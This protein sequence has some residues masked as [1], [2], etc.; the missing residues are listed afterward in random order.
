MGERARRHVAGRYAGQVSPPEHRSDAQ[1]HRV[2]CRRRRL[3]LDRA[4]PAAQ[5]VR[6]VGHQRE[7]RVD[8][9]RVGGLPH[10]RPG[11]RILAGHEHRTRGDIQLGGPAL[12]FDDYPTMLRERDTDLVGLGH[13]DVVMRWQPGVLRAHTWPRQRLGEARVHSPRRSCHHGSGQPQTTD[14]GRSCS[15]MPWSRRC[16]GA[17]T[18]TGPGR[19]VTGSTG[20]DGSRFLGQ[21]QC[22]VV[23][24]C[25]VPGGETTRPGLVPPGSRAPPWGGRLAGTA[26]G[27][28]SAWQGWRLVGWVRSVGQEPPGGRASVDPVGRPAPLPPGDPAPR[29]CRLGL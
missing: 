11:Q 24:G 18:R 27:I 7:V 17:S 25:A 5:P 8:L 16:T 20:A 14:G 10:P 3:D 28:R 13:G 23:A 19:W 2:L 6:E 26:A 29:W 21:R 1:D 15:F 9:Q 4:R 12:A 22:S